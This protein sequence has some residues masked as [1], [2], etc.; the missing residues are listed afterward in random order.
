MTAAELM[1]IDGELVASES[2]E[3]LDSTNPADERPLGRVPLANKRDA[4]KA[5]AAAVAAAPGWAATTPT[6]RE[7]YMREFARR[8]GELSREFL[9]IE[10]RDTGNTIKPMRGDVQIS[11]NSLHYYGGLAHEV[12]GETIPATSENLHITIREPFGPVLR[13]TP[14]NHPLMFAV[15][16]TA[17]ALAAGNPVIVKPSETSPL[18]TALLAT[19]AKEVF[20][21]G[22]FNIVT[23]LGMTV[24]DALVRHPDIWRIGFTGSVP[25]G[26]AIQRAAAEVSVKRLT[27]ELGGKNPLIAFPDADPEEVA[28]AAVRGMNFSWQGQSCGSTSRLM[29]HEDIHDEVLARIEAIVSALRIGDPLSEDTDMGPINSAA[30]YQRVM[31]MIGVAQEGGARLVTGGDRPAGNEFRK[32][33]WV[34][35]TVFAGVTGDM[36]IAREEV[37]GPVLSVLKWSS[38]EDAIRVANSVEYGLTASVFTKDIKQAVRTARAVQSGFVWVNGTSSH[39]TGVP[40]G[41]YKNSGVG[42]EE[43]IEELLSYTQTKAI[44]FIL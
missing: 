41:G 3:W 4:D 33:F 26:L 8:I 7:Q 20:P 10:V 13:I 23:G 2:G 1:L 40:F 24:G 19:V 42:N 37:F 11:V 44:N 43:G 28:V 25:T 38:V 32:G 29:L 34:A 12:K 31:K 16:K 21:K 22:V 17:A 9:E 35:P 18:S 39:F 15:S 27:L 5:V 14:F 36:R 30:H 6:E